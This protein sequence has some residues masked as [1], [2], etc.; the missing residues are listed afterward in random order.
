VDKGSKY[1][2]LTQIVSITTEFHYTIVSLHT[3]SSDCHDLTLLLGSKRSAFASCLQE[4]RKLHYQNCSIREV[5]MRLEN[6]GHA[7]VNFLEALN[8]ELLDFQRQSLQWALERE[9]LP[10]PVPC[11][12]PIR[13]PQTR[14]DVLAVSRPFWY[15]LPLPFRKVGKLGLHGTI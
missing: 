15:Q 9:K 1:R 11:H 2:V 13:H 7:K 5:M 10:D 4:A 12:C 6:I 8:V 3:D 14:G